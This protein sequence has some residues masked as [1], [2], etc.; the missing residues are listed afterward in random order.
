MKTIH[1]P[2]ANI[3]YN[4]TEH[5]LHIKI[6]EDAEMNLENTKIHYKKINDLVGDH[7]YLALVE[8]SNYCSVE[9]EA[10]QYSSLR[11]IVLNRKAT[12]HY[13]S[14]FANKLTTSFFK[15]TFKTTTPVQIFNT[16]EDALEWLKSFS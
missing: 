7:S 1:T 3:S 2:L 11:K 5:I 8:A 9:K 16:K 15:T 12:A 14:C 10:W 6:Q 4:E 13:N